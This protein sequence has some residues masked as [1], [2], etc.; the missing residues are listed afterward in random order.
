[1]SRAA[2]D[3]THSVKTRPSGTAQSCI[4]GSGLVTRSQAVCRVPRM[5]GEKGRVCQCCRR[6]VLNSIPS[7]R[8]MSQA[9]S[10]SETRPSSTAQVCTSGSRFQTESLLSW[11]E[12]ARRKRTCLP[13]PPCLQPPLL[14]QSLH[15]VSLDSST[16]SSQQA[17]P[18]PLRHAPEASS[19]S[20]RGRYPPALR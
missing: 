16:A 3:R 13:M 1:M 19:C 7:G 6:P 15:R 5:L 8:Q 9:D 4:S 12:D 20:R 18:S 14:L 11:F 10:S 17:L 2:P